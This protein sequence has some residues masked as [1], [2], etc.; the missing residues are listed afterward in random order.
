MYAVEGQEEKH[1]RRR[2]SQ[3]PWRCRRDAVLLLESIFICKTKTFSFLS[4]D[5]M[6]MQMLAGDGLKA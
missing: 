2:G 6:Q 1:R 3:L 4:L 5:P